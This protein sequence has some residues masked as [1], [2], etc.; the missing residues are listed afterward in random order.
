MA[1]TYDQGDVE[2]RHNNRDLYDLFINGR[3]VEYDVGPEQHDL[4]DAVWRARCSTPTSQWRIT[5]G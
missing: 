2:F 3:I 5:E 4:V 1:R